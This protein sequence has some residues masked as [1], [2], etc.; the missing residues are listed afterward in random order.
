M[1][2]RNPSTKVR[3]DK[4]KGCCS[5][6]VIVV[7]SIVGNVIVTGIA[8]LF[9]VHSQNEL[10]HTIPGSGSRSQNNQSLAKRD[11]QLPTPPPRNSLVDTA[12]FIHIGKTG[13]STISKL[14]RNGCTSFITGPCRNV[15]DETVVSKF[16]VGI[17]F[18]EVMLFFV[19]RLCL[20]LNW[21][22]DRNIIIT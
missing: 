4:R 7:F 9:L 18:C 15:T 5:I 16:V 10:V 22:F 11:P 21:Y 17:R 20:T 6:L 19:S 2:S 12:G 8:G 1:M 14:L 3:R 13:G